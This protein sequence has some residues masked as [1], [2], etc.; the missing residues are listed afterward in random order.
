MDQET[1]SRDNLKF[2]KIKVLL[3]EIN[4]VL[5]EIQI[6][7][8]DLL[9]LVDVEAETVDFVAEILSVFRLGTIE[10]G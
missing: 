2:N 1:I 9:M 8:E 3:G 7:F 5:V 6:C 10:Q 4:I